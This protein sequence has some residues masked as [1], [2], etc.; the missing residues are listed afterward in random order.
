MR[1]IQQSNHRN[2]GRSKECGP[3]SQGLH[4][5][6]EIRP[7]R[8]KCFQS[9]HASVSDISPECLVVLA[10]RHDQIITAARD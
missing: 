4:D 9:V 6:P 10:Q 8:F 5:S 2:Y 7:T 3:R 1:K